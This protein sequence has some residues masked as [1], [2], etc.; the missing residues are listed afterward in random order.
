[1]KFEMV[2]IMV[3]I[4]GIIAIANEIKRLFKIQ[5]I[6]PLKSIAN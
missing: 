5:R 2:L 1:M 3:I 6:V 4:Y